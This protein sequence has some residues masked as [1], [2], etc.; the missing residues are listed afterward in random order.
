MSSWNYTNIAAI[1]TAE[2]RVLPFGSYLAC[3]Q[4]CYL[5][6]SFGEKTVIR[7]SVKEWCYLPIVIA[8]KPAANARYV[9]TK[10]WMLSRVVDKDPYVLPDLR[11]R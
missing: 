1:K 11:E 2:E 9:K 5:F 4:T 8:C 10:L 3:M 6:P 7:R